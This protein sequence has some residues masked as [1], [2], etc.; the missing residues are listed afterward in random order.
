MVQFT[1]DG[2]DYGLSQRSDP[3]GITGATT[4]DQVVQDS[5]GLVRGTPVTLP[6][7]GTAYLG[8]AGLQGGSDDGSRRAVPTGPSAVTWTAPGS[9]YHL[10]GLPYATEPGGCGLD[11]PDPSALLALVTVMR[12]VDGAGWRAFLDEHSDV[13]DQTIGGVTVPASAP[14]TTLPEDPPADQRS[15]EDQIAAV[16][17]GWDH[18]AADGTYPNLEDG[19]AKAAEYAEMFATAATQSGADQAADK[20]GNTTKLSNVHFVTP[21][22]ATITMA[23]GAVLPTGTFTF[24]QEGEAI[25]QD[26]RW[27]VTYRTV[28]TTLGRACLPPGGY[29]GCPSR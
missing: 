20:S 12:Y 8:C 3:L 6:G 16:V 5:L 14:P 23:M 9:S 18:K 17:A 27:V 7:I 19:S 24:T 4:V 13:T 2:R 22:R 29:D 10:T 26:G 1:L 15:A 21:Q 25:L 28:T 11:D